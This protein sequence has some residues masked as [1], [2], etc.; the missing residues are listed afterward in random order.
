MPQPKKLT[1]EMVDGTTRTITNLEFLKFFWAMFEKLPW[2]G[3]PSRTISQV[4]TQ[5]PAKTTPPTA[6]PKTQ[7]GL[8]KSLMGGAKQALPT[9]K[10]GG[11]LSRAKP[12]EP[13]PVSYSES[14]DGRSVT[15]HNV[16]AT[17]MAASGNAL[18]LNVGGR[19]VWF[20]VAMLWDGSDIRDEGDEGDVVTSTEFAEEKGLLGGLGC[21]F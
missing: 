10:P 21:P 3:S 6:A 7:G 1:V 12:A 16:R 15:I 11:V 9:P 2:E 17:K 13:D 19:K 8:M 5:A 20:P 14:E 4:M 18:L